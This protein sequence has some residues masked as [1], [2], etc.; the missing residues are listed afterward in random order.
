[1]INYVIVAF[2]TL[3]IELMGVAATAGVL[4]L[5]WNILTKKSNIDLY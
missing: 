3:F 2:E 4:Y 1:M 5:Y